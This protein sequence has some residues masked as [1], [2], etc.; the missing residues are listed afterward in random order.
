MEKQASKERHRECDQLTRYN[1]VTIQSATV[2]DIDGDRRHGTRGRDRNAITHCRSSSRSVSLSLL[3]HP[4]FWLRG[5]EGQMTFTHAAD[6]GSRAQFFFFQLYWTI[7]DKKCSYLFCSVIFWYVHT[8]WNDYLNKLINTSP[9]SVVC[10]V[11][12][13]KMYSISKFPVYDPILLTIVIIY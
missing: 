7:I 12:S 4:Q 10:V 5:T 1:K 8:L 6:P 13:F 11:R 2:Y 9:P 3:S